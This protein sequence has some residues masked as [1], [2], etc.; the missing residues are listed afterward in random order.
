[1]TAQY[2]PVTSQNMIKPKGTSR[3]WTQANEP[4][5]GLDVNEPT[6]LYIKALET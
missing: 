6:T 1:M 2:N 3:N 4:K 5:T